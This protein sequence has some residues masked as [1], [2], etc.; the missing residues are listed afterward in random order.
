[1]GYLY[2]VGRGEV[3]W[4]RDLVSVLKVGWCGLHLHQIVVLDRH[5][6]LVYYKTQRG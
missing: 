5:S 4:A 6:N 2:G 3:K 1:M